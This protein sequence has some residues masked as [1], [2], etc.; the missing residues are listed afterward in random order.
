[1]KVF[2]ERLLGQPRRSWKQCSGN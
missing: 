2:I 1:M